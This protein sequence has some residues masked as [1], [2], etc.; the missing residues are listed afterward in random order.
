MNHLRPFQI[1]AR[2]LTVFLATL[3]AATTVAAQTKRF[4]ATSL[5][6]VKT[7][8]ATRK[9]VVQSRKDAPRVARQSATVVRKGQMKTSVSAAV[10]DVTIATG[11]SPPGSY[12]P[13]SGLGVTPLPG[14]SDDSVTDFITPAYTFAGET[15]TKV[16]FSSNGYALIGGTTDLADNTTV[17]QSFPDPTLP[18]NVL[19]P[20]WTDLDPESAG[21]LYIAVVTDGSDDWV[22]LDWENV[23]E[24]SSLNSN[25]FEIWIGLNGDA[26][27]GEDISYVYGTIGGS[28]N[29][30]L[31]TVGAENKFGTHGQNY[32]FNGTGTLP[33]LGTQLRVTTT[34]CVVPTP[35]TAAGSTGS[36]DEDSFSKASVSN[37][38]LGFNPGAT[39]TITARYNITANRGIS[40]FCPATMSHIAIRFRDVDSSGTAAQVILTIHQSNVVSGGNTTIFTF[41]SNVSALPTGAA[42]QTFSTDVPIGFD[43]SANI[44]WIEVQ[45]IRSDPNAFANFGSIDIFASEGTACP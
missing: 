43:F 11:A 39:G 34:S 12:L 23:T 45:V 4:T 16:G 5:T 3:L 29:G 2:S 6:P 8:S 32:Y 40:A 17:N 26:N 20:F 31:L 44:Y 22:V 38:V 30:G 24:F 9:V 25:S 18:N 37:F 7:I 14:V 21:A 13:L 36:I 1:S 33:A 35:W 19:A 42:F 41:D 15:Y 27:P 10:C 28:G